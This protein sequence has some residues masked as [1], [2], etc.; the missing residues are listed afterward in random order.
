[1]IIIVAPNAPIPF[2][3]SIRHGFDF[4]NNIALPIDK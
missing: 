3:P 1:M 4:C 2:A